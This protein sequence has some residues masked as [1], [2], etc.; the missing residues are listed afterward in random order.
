MH[1]ILLFLLLPTFLIASIEDLLSDRQDPCLVHHVNVI[2][3][4]LNLCM[5]DAEVPG[6]LPYA[7]TRTYTSAGALER[8]SNEI[9]LTLKAACDG[10]LIQGGW[11]LLP[12]T[13][14][15][16]QPARKLKYRSFF[17]TEANGALV[18]YVHKEEKHGGHVFEPKAA[19]GQNIAGL[20]YRT[21]PYNNRLF[22]EEGRRKII[23]TLADG[24]VRTY[25]RFRRADIGGQLGHYQLIKEV[26]P[27]KHEIHYQYD[28]EDHL[29]S[30][31][32][33]SPWGDLT[34]SSVHFDLIKIGSEKKPFHFQVTTS[35]GQRLDYH[36]L[37]HKQRHYLSEVESN[38]R[39]HESIHYVPGRSGLGARVR[40]LELDHK[41]QFYVYYNEPSSEKRN[42]K[43]EEDPKSTPF[44]IDKVQRLEAPLG[45][46]GE[47][48]T[49]ATFSYDP[50]FTDVVD[51]EGILTRYHHDE[52]HLLYIEYFNEKRQLHSTLKWSWKGARL[53]G[54]TLL[55]A[56]G[57]L[58]FAKTFEYDKQ[59]NVCKETFSGN[60]IE[61]YSKFYIYDTKTHL[62]IEEKEEGG[63]CYR[64]SYLPGTA[65]LASKTT[66]DLLCETFLYDG[67]H[68]PICE[69]LLA[70]GETHIT[71]TLRDP[72]TAL[73]ITITELY[74]DNGIEKQLRRTD[75]TYQHRRVHT[76]T[77]YDKDNQFC[78]TLTTTYDAA[79]HIL[80]KTTP[81]G[82]LNTY[83][84]NAQG[85]LI[86]SKEEGSPPLH[87]T[88]NL[89]GLPTSR[90]EIDHTTTFTY[91][92]KGRLT[93]TLSPEGDLTTQ[94]YDPFGNCL[95]T[96]LPTSCLHFT[97]DIMGNLTSTTNPLGS[98][99][100]TT[101]N[102][103]RKPLTITN[104][105]GAITHHRYDKLGNLITTLYPDGT[106]LLCT[107][108]PL[109]RKLSETILSSDNTLLSRESWTYNALHL[110]SHTN[111][112]GSVTTSH[113][114][115]A[116]L[117]LSETT[118]DRTTTY[119]YDSLSRLESTTQGA[120][121]LVEKHN[122]AGQVITT[123]SLTPEIE[124]LTHYLY[125]IEGRKIQATRQG[126]DSFEYDNRN[127]LT[128]HTDP[129]GNTTLFL[130][131]D[132]PHLK[133]TTIDPLGNR[134]ITSYD[135]ANRLIS[136]ENQ[137]PSSHTVGL[138]HYSYNTAGLCTSRQTTV[139]Q[140]IT[141]I[142]DLVTS[143]EYDA[144]GRV[145]TEIN[146]TQ[147]THYTYTPR[148]HLATKML[149][150]GITL[151]YH[152]DGLG[153]LIEQ[154]SHDIHYL[155]FYDHSSHPSHIDDLI[156]HTR[157]HRR[158]N[159]FD[160]LI[161]EINP[162]G[163]TTQWTYNSLG[164]RSTLT[165]PDHTHILYSYTGAHLTSVSRPTYSHHYLTF[166]PYGHPTSASLINNLPL[167][168]N[169][170][171]LDRP[172]SQTSP[173]LSHSS[174][175]G[176]SGLVLSTTNSLFGTETFTYDPLNQLS[177]PY[178]FDSVGNPTQYTTNELNQL[179]LFTYDP[180]GNPTSRGYTYDALSRLT[181]YNY[182]YD[183]FSRLIK[184][185]D[186][187]YLYDDLEEIGTCTPDG[188]ILELKVIGLAPIAIELNNIH[189]TPLLDFSN[190]II[191]LLSPDGS[192]FETTHTDPFGASSLLPAHN[193]WRFSSKR[194]D[195]SLVYF[196]KRFYDPATSRF[197]TPDPTPESVN[198][199]V[200]VLNNP[201][202]RLDLFGLSSEPFFS[203][204]IPIIDLPPPNFRRMIPCKGHTGQAEEQYVVIYDDWHRLKFT[205]EEQ[206][207]GSANIIDHLHELIPKEGACIGLITEQNG[208]WTTYPALQQTSNFTMSNI[209]EGTLYIGRYNPKEGTFA[210]VTRVFR[211]KRGTDTATISNTRQ[212][213]V[214]LLDNI[215][216]INPNMG[217]LHFS[218]SEAGLIAN[219]AI[220]GMTP[221]QKSRLEQHLHSDSYGPAEPVAKTHTLSSLNTYSTQDHITKRFATDYLNH[222]NYNIQFVECTTPR[223]E[224]AF[225][226][227][228]HSIMGTT[229]KDAKIQNIKKLRGTHGFHNPKTH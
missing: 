119:T 81:S 199:Y 83:S 173:P 79:G 188:H 113:Y 171:L 143:W 161:E 187:L 6:A 10:W 102:T 38:C 52:H 209:H 93:S 203:I 41:P 1:Q 55:D 22:V 183:A 35:G 75:Y 49:L 128:C 91:D 135:A 185:D 217:W 194:C 67:N 25:K 12:H 118:L 105:D 13:H 156:H 174:T 201:L 145:I 214:A 64:Y 140:N 51:S 42:K 90:T 125:D 149:P 62:L 144:E 108:D 202:N 31:H 220:D 40:F 8:T 163:L 65:L 162:Y 78:Y 146:A 134:T 111:P 147:I 45:P 57:K 54:K 225:W 50:K 130:Y 170:D 197:L 186:I 120:L 73:P 223:S 66:G 224:R 138:T 61:S 192:L 177:T 11:S 139:F 89:A 26:S 60:Q 86:S 222:P 63:L 30:I 132:L 207:S 17:L 152:Y 200:Y 116:G 24:T 99:H 211:E 70:D 158:Y 39:P 29:K 126:V 77:L 196:G 100:T 82:A 76:E 92:P 205:P 154:Q 219:R 103:L 215:H 141:P 32:V 167:S 59:G 46:N 9:D 72:H 182:T 184:Q 34:F 150:S 14:L 159:A 164:P 98:T 193:P 229:Y 87:H 216:A 71:R 124:Q 19:K 18:T 133:K 190:H 5:Q 2:S 153:R 47:S 110:L 85:D 169:Y 7:L 210:D 206:T 68:L 123:Y 23:L 221:D 115:A 166:D 121:T 48:V 227:A 204:D 189:Y 101:Y 16:E 44:Y 212:F 94:T 20:S 142:R 127:R 179:S 53:L 107:Y 157:L 137:D 165:L 122:P 109:H 208:I 88:Y 33:T 117:L 160:E 148:G 4:H 36:S 43:W 27:N 218:H 226:I 228:D 96:T 178:S 198:L 213:M 74:L 176:P 56:T 175:Y 84:Y 21:N 97:Y 69:T 114:D 155:Y 80:S 131:E 172:L 181:S 28:H 191:A 180:D 3:G 112:N 151:T 129:L 168:T 15:F 106:Q 37:L 136:E 58:L 195:H 104:A 95:S